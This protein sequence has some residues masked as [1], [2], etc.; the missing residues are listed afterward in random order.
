MRPRKD[1][2]RKL[3]SG[4]PVQQMFFRL[5]NHHCLLWLWTG[6]ATAISPAERANLYTALTLH[7][8]LEIQSPAEERTGQIQASL[9]QKSEQPSKVPESERGSRDAGL[10][11]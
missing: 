2:G 7:R 8:L 10:P 4:G 11:I 9:T 5:Q 6:D 3:L 1:S